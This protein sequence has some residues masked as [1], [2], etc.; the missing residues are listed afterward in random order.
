MPN[1]DAPEQD[2]PPNSM[3]AAQT[4]M[5]P[6]LPKR[7][8]AAAGV[9]AEGD[10]FR[11]VL[12]GRGVKTPARR[13]LCLPDADLANAVAAEWDSQQTV[14]DPA[15]MPLTRLVNSAID[16][17]A[18]NPAA[19]AEEIARYAGSDLLCYRAGEP[20][21]LVERQAQAW[22]PILSW[23]R[24]MFGLRF[25]LGE[26]V[27][28]VAQPE[29]TL[30]TFAALLPRQPLTLAG[31]SSMTTLTGSALLAFGVW[32]GQVAGETAWNAAH[33]DEEFQIA[34]W[35]EDEEAM[36]RRDLRRRE[37]DA[38]VRLLAQPD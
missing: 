22:D 5:R 15:L 33:V 38:A 30:A 18:D 11:V 34:V 35:G 14:I 3:R 7:F 20:R 24:E 4:A 10:A 2:G 16:G 37:F 32:K 36:A 26:G 6:P 12:D 23:L 28:F 1:R 25:V 29:A 13:P 8:Y 21:S 9:M 27:M 31:L 17:V 19:V